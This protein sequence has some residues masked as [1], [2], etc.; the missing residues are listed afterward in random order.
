[1]GAPTVRISRLRVVRGGQVVIPAL[2]VEVP[3][4]QVVGLL[5]TSGCGKTTL[6]RC[7][8]GVQLIADGNVDVLDRP[9]GHP[10]L[11]HRADA[12][13]VILSDSTRDGMSVHAFH[14]LTGSSVKG[15]IPGAAN[16]Y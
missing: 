16:D 7:M 3:R 8:V 14:A 12:V 6:M 1:M 15:L 10:D 13:L 2:T 9:A 5:S 4:G 11:R